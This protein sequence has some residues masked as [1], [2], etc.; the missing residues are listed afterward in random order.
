MRLLMIY[1]DVFS[2]KPVIKTLDDADKEAQPAS[3]EKAIVG[4]IHAEAEDEEKL[5]AVETKLVKN[6]KWA[7][8]KNDTQKIVLHSFAHLSGSKADPQTTKQLLNQAEI[9]LQN[10]GYE[11]FQTPFGYF[12]DLKV[13]AP[14]HPLARLFKEF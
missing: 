13:D 2:Y 10:S 12:L 7:A 14:G 5:S 8:R 9:R 11:T 6:L 3:I 1:A 4:F